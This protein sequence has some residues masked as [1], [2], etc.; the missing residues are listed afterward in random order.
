MRVTFIGAGR[1]A[2]AL[3]H[4]MPPEYKIVAVASRGPSADRLA[5]EVGCTRLSLVDTALA[6]DLVFI[7]TP[8]AA[9]AEVAHRIGM[10]GGWRPGQV[11]VH[12]SGAL[13]SEVLDELR[14]FH[15][16]VASFHP[17]QSFSEGPVD[18]RGVV[19]AL[20]G[21]AGAVAVLRDLVQ[22]MGGV[23]LELE[24]RAKVL[25]HVAA[26]LVSNY[27][28]TLVATAVA[29]L[30]ELGLE[31]HLALKGL[32]SLLR[33]TVANLEN[34]GLPRALTGPIARGDA[35][36][37]RAHLQALGEGHRSVA[38]A[39]RT[40]GVLTLPVAR[41]AGMGDE[42]GWEVIESILEG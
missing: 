32:L 17:L 40:L 15:C 16:S 6:G 42:R 11:V 24:P 5:R 37:V 20:E 23:P 14:N 7:A 18:L 1:V 8:D 13:T 29:L 10:E 38:E 3:A 25:Y 9:I 27:T 36:T 30:V 34:V 21:D 41:A 26:V 35:V 19:F 28:V 31:G 22:K 4:A 12:L 33:G 39:Y 2:R